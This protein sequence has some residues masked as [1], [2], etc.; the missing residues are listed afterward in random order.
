MYVLTQALKHQF[1][2]IYINTLE[3]LEGVGEI[4]CSIISNWGHCM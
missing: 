1:H 4:L 2:H 3:H